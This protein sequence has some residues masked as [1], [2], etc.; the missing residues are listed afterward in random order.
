MIN[1][2][3]A[4]GIPGRKFLIW[5]FMKIKILFFNIRDL[6]PK[7]PIYSPKVATLTSYHPSSPLVGD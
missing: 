5:L 6:L 2:R 7:K 1:F 3:E 4:S